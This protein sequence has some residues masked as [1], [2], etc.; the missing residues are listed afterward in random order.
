ML[1]HIESFTKESID[2][3]KHSVSTKIA[4]SLGA[5]I[6]LLAYAPNSI[7]SVTHLQ[8]HCAAFVATDKEKLLQVL[9]EALTVEARRKMSQFQLEAAKTYH[10]SEVNSQKL[11]KVLMQLH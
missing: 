11:H 2:R 6:P 4:D 5:G 9:T 10:S 7:A 8:K 1:L 3:V